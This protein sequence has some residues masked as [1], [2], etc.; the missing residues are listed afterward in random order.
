[1]RHAAARFVTDA[2]LA[3]RQ[4][5]AKCLIATDDE[6]FTYNYKLSRLTAIQEH[7]MVLRAIKN[8]VSEARIAKPLDLDVATIRQKL[9]LLDGISQ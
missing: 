6:G 2:T 7:F 8:G 3:S 4:P 1:L 5:T 9:D